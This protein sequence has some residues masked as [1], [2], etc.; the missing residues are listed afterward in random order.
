M[1]A[2][3]WLAF[4]VLVAQAHSAASSN[5][6]EG[7]NITLLNLSLAQNNSTW[8]GI[9]GSVSGSAFSNVTI[10]ATPG[11]VECIFTFATGS[12]G[13]SNGVNSTFL[14]FSNSSANFT[15]L[16]AG[17]L[18]VLDSFI[19][20][21][22]ESGTATFTS[23]RTFQTSGWGNITSVPSTY[24]EPSSPQDFPEGYLQ[25]SAGNLVFITPAVSDKTGFNGSLYDFQAILPTNGGQNT[26]YYLR[27]D[28]GC[29]AANETPSPP[30]TP[31]PGGGGTFVTPGFSIPYFAAVPPITLPAKPPTALDIRVLRFSPF[32]EVGAGE[33]AVINPLIENPTGSFMTISIGL[34][35]PEA[36]LATPSQNVLLAPGEKKTVP[37]SIRLPPDM[38]P[39]YYA[40]SVLLS[41]NDTSITYPAIVRVVPSYRIGEPVVRRQF[42]L[43]YENNETLVILAVTNRG[44]ELISHLQIFETLP[45]KL[46]S[47]SEAI[48]FTTETGTIG[49]DIAGTIKGPDIRWDVQNIHPDESRAIFYRVP[50]LLTDLSEYQAW[51]VAQLVAIQGGGPDIQL[52]N[53]QAPSL[54]PGERGELTVSLFNAGVVDREVELGIVPPTGWKANPSSLSLT[55]PFREVETV[56]FVLGSPASAAAGTYGFTLHVSY[57]D[58]FYDKFAYVYVNRPIVEIFA[59]PIAD[60]LSAFLGANAVLVVFALV[61][62]G[63]LLAGLF[64]AYRTLN[65]PRFDEGRLSDMQNLQRMFDQKMGKKKGL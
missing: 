21:E 39:G 25:D 43:D 58:V 26:T 28:L 46:A 37:F 56:S 53:L 22:N 41:F 44:T 23:S 20:S 13:C 60:Q 15:A 27:V 49:G 4:L 14:L 2:F 35:G 61:A 54:L 42:M 47:L 48:K 62:G 8:Y 7:G 3:A 55:V 19:N 10:N 50:K 1:K 59:P 5:A 18:T 17:N 45:E 36:A 32:R 31:S 52:R 65:Q 24:T 33:S 30:P 9:C 29:N 34:S 11:A 51:N 38:P 6:T 12:S 63:L 16:S 57:A 40:F 64:F